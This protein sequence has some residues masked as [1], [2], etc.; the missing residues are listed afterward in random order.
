MNTQ[1]QPD[2][3]ITIRAV[4]ERLELSI[5]SVYRLIKARRFPKPVKVGGAT[6]LFE[7]DVTAFLSAL[8][9]DESTKSGGAR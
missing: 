9:S 2:R 4:A 3:L 1:N 7:S 8:R 6:R 5:R